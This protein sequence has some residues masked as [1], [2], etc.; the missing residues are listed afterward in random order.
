MKTCTLCGVTGPDLHKSSPESSGSHHCADL[1]GCR[2]RR[3]DRS[4]RRRAIA[5]RAAKAQPIFGRQWRD[6]AE[7]EDAVQDAMVRLERINFIG[8]D[9]CLWAWCSR[10]IRNLWIDYRRRDRRQVSLQCLIDQGMEV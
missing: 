7:C 2:L 8:D 1:A 9:G 4:A 5:V 6:D 10:V 3:E